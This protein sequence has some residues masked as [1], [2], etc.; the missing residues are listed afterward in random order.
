M[1]ALFV[2]VTILGFALTV[3]VMRA[4]LRWPIR[5]SFKKI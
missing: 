3:R 2:I 1:T 5:K 4:I